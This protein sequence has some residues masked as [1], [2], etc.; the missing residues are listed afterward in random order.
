[1]PDVL[2]ATMMPLF[3]RPSQQIKQKYMNLLCMYTHT[4]ICTPMLLSYFYHLTYHHQNWY[5]ILYQKGH[6]KAGDLTDK[7]WDHLES[8]SFTHLAVD[9][10]CQLV[11]L[12]LLARTPTRV[13][14]KQPVFLHGMETLR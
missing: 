4:H 11:L 12:R 1:M 5:R 2:I 9:A 13:V 6:G 14:S 3:P 7:S 10:G 8:L